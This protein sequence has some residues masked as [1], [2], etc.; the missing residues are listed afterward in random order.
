MAGCLDNFQINT[1]EW[2][3][4]SEKRNAVA[5]IIAGV[6]V[7]KNNSDV[8]LPSMLSYISSIVSISSSF[9]LVGG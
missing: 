5:S 6:L 2:L 7:S 3:N 8:L 9:S 4:L 1:P